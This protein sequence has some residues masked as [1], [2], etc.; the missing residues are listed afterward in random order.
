MTMP[1]RCPSAIQCFTSHSIRLSGKIDLRERLYQW[2][3]AVLCYIVFPFTLAWKIPLSLSGSRR[4][5]V[6]SSS[7]TPTSG[8]TQDFQEACCILQVGLNG[9]DNGSLRF[10]GVRIPRVNLLDRF[11]QVDRNGQY[12]SPFSS[13]RRFAATL[14]ELTGGRVGLSCA[15]LGILKVSILPKFIHSSLV[16]RCLG[17]LLAMTCSC[18]IRIAALYRLLLQDTSLLSPL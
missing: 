2:A 1:T 12:S 8:K 9:V 17:R 14:G 6:C 4:E 5:N 7:L 10:T 13:S 16:A 15:S 3:L 18:R 11:G